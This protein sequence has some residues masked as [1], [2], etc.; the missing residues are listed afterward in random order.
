M[1]S[2]INHEEV[3]KKIQS[4]ERD[5]GETVNPWT[6]KVFTAAYQK[7]KERRSQLA[8]YKDKYVLEL[9][10]AL[11]ATKVIL[12]K[13]DTGAG[14]SSGI[15][16]ILAWWQ[17]YYYTS[18]LKK[19]VCVLPRRVA[20]EACAATMAKLMDVE[21]GGFVGYRVDGKERISTK[22]GLEFVTDSLL[23]RDLIH[24]PDM[25]RH[26]RILVI[27]EAHERTAATDELLQILYKHLWDRRDFKLIIM[28]ATMDTSYFSGCLIGFKPIC[29]NMQE[30]RAFELEIEYQRDSLS[31]EEKSTAILNLLASED[32]GDV[33][34]FLPS[35]LEI[36][37]LW[38][39]FA[40]Q[41]PMGVDVLT[42]YKGQ[43]EAQQDAATRCRPEAGVK[44]IIF[45]DEVAE[46][47][48]TIQGLDTVIDTGLQYMESYIPSICTT[49]RTLQAISKAS[50]DQR[51][52]RAARTKNGQCIRLYTSDDYARMSLYTQSCIIRERYTMSMLR[53]LIRE[54][55]IDVTTIERFDVPPFEYCNQ[56]FRDLCR[57]G[58][59]T[60]AFIP[61]AK[62]KRVARFSCTFEMACLLSQ[63]LMDPNSNS[64]CLFIAMAA[65]L[66][67]KNHDQIIAAWMIRD[68]KKH[69]NQRR[70]L[71]RNC[72]GD[73]FIY[74]RVGSV[75]VR[76][77]PTDDSYKPAD[78]TQD[79]YWLQDLV[80]EM[81]HVAIPFKE[82]GL[83]RSSSRVPAWDE[84]WPLHSDDN[85]ITPAQRQVFEKIESR[86]KTVF[87]F[88]C[89]QHM[90]NGKYLYL[91]N[92]YTINPKSILSNGYRSC[93]AQ[94]H[95]ASYIYFSTLDYGADGQLC[96]SD[97]IVFDDCQW[98]QQ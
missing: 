19:I 36:R 44:R 56:A 20:T 96:I 38:T 29:I 9:H 2:E 67:L 22:T 46:S 84:A 49:V 21:L 10:R 5:D 57:N 45:A 77:D 69:G 23:V 74:G 93:W 43:S 79:V 24:Q 8:V 51:A 64:H 66:N 42:L 27:D 16:Q 86:M 58:C 83:L 28:S 60:P 95:N 90:E 6:G 1:A 73:L 13:A 7:N 85:A 34:V 82:K 78:D 80:S 41:W 25:L 89:A 61:T 70:A 97:G 32:T 88:R 15:P 4:F 30:P 17:A 91:A 31:Q 53:T 98:V 52:G 14:K 40:S 55:G 75:M 39:R 68:S 71:E 18:D 37:A 12:I 72:W 92:T 35:V 33:L 50:A 47:M 63:E 81:N 48:L 94:L 26:I 59:I 54:P 3:L 87:A 11:R 65:A 76:Y 62:G